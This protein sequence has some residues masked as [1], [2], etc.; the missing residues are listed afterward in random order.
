VNPVLA[1]I[2]GLHKSNLINPKRRQTRPKDATR[3][4]CKSYDN[5]CKKL[6]EVKNCTARRPEISQIRRCAFWRKRSLH[7]LKNGGWT[8]RPRLSIQW[9]FN[10]TNNAKQ[11]EV[12]GL[13]ISPTYYMLHISVSLGVVYYKNKPNPLL[14]SFTH[15][16]RQ[17][18]KKSRSVNQ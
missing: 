16:A 4:D 13:L 5:H 8:F 11:N 9:E 12:R 2:V 3:K 18:G 7:K 6:A 10:R 17:K 1:G 15:P 14:L